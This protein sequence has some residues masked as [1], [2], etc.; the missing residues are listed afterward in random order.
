[1]PGSVVSVAVKPGDVVSE[2][3]EVA[4]VEA[5]KMQNVLHASRAGKVKSVQVKAGQSVQA[6]E[7]LIEFEPEESA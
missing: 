7:T 2:G 6:D 5:M 1:M 4:I 3:A